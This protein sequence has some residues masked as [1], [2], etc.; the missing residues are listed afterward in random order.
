M[1]ALAMTL[2]GPGED[3]RG[4]ALC[5]GKGIAGFVECSLYLGEQDPG[6]A[7]LVLVFIFLL[8]WLDM[9]QAT[10]FWQ[11][12]ETKIRVG[13]GG[14]VSPIITSLPTTYHLL[15]SKDVLFSQQ[16]SLP[17]LPQLKPQSPPFTDPHQSCP[18]TP[19]SSGGSSPAQHAGG[20]QSTWCQ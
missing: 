16:T 6:A 15:T 3:L 7:L 19:S 20:S 17:H 13:G 14:G 1:V 4:A 18:T 9:H 2:L 8:G 12:E 5:L 11:L 10:L